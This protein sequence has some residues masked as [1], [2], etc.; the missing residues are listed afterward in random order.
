[1]AIDKGKSP[2]SIYVEGRQAETFE[3]CVASFRTGGTLGLVGGLRVLGSSR[4]KIV[5]RVRILK[6]KGITPYDVMTGCTDGTELLSAAIAAINGARGMG[7]DPRT[8]GL[9]GRRGGKQKGVNAQK[10][11]DAIMHEA[12]VARICTHPKLDWTDRA[13][14]LGENFSAS[15]LRRLYGD[16]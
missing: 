15:T 2:R 6:A 1:M 5:A 14:I 10:K 11:R 7:I 4:V 16:N 3:T 13:E 9:R 8:P 12:V